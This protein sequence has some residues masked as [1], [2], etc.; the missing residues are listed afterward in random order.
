LSLNDS[1]SQQRCPEGVCRHLIG[2]DDHGVRP[3]Q[4]RQRPARRTI[5]H[6]GRRTVQ[7][8]QGGGHHRGQFLDGVVDILVEYV[9]PSAKQ[10]IPVL[11][12]HRSTAPVMV[13]DGGYSYHPVDVLER[14]IEQ[15]PPLYQGRTLNRRGPEEILS[16][17]QDT[18]TNRRSGPGYTGQRKTARWIVDRV[19]GNDHR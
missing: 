6:H 11:H 19:V 1:F 5:G 14:A 15:W 9:P 4:I 3:F 16:R 10:T 2:T 18:G 8:D 13:F 17:Q 12:G 7:N